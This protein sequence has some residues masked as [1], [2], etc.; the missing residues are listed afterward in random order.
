[1]IK[2]CGDDLEDNNSGDN[3]RCQFNVVFMIQVFKLSAVIKS[4]FHFEVRVFQLNG[5]V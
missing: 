2:N 4:I 1:M 5:F 3:R